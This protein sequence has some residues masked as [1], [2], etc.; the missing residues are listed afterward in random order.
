MMIAMTSHGYR[1]VRLDADINLEKETAEYVVTDV[2]GHKYASSDFKGMAQTYKVLAAK[3][4]DAY[5][6]EKAAA[7]K[8]VA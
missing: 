8:E 7:G 3:F 2:D 1:N 5:A 4:E 6:A